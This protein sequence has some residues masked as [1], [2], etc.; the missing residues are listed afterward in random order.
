MLADTKAGTDD[1]AFLQLLAAHSLQR[2]PADNAS[3]PPDGAL[4]TA[5]ATKTDTEKIIKLS[6]S[7]LTS[8]SLQRR[9][10]HWSNRSWPWQRRPQSTTVESADSPP[11]RPRAGGTH[12]VGLGS[13]VQPR[14][15]V[16]GIRQRR[17]LGPVCG[18]RERSPGRVLAGHTEAVR[19]VA[20]SPDGSRLA[21]ASFDN[22]VGVW[23]VAQTGQPDLTLRH[24]QRSVRSCLQPDG[25]QLASAS[26]D[27]TVRLWDALRIDADWRTA[28]PPNASARRRLQPDGTLLATGAATDV[29]V[30]NSDWRQA[31][32]SAAAG[33]RWLVVRRGVQKSGSQDHLQ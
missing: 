23:D 32:P 33:T 25:A 15:L 21:T 13:G 2:P 4:Y 12:V 5:V 24:W 20:F 8:P 18:D 11:A 3:P 10:Q 31:H 19:R 26:D 17:P 6:D 14:W 29:K 22:N 1:Q 30:W 9:G 27:G 7:R 28:A 16:T